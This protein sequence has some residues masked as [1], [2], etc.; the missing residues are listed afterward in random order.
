M[1]H[2]SQMLVAGHIDLDV[3]H[4]KLFRN[5]FQQSNGG[6]MHSTPLVSALLT[7]QKQSPLLGHN[8]WQ[9]GHYS[10]IGILVK[11]INVCT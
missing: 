6:I 1:A 8:V 11:Y 5:K 3:R 7:G 10:G 9:I 4:R 2:L